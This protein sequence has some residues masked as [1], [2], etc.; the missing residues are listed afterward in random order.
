MYWTC[1][2]SVRSAGCSTYNDWL[3]S[4]L[5]E[6][7]RRHNR[8]EGGK[9]APDRSKSKGNGVGHS[10]IGIHDDLVVLNRDDAR[11]PDSVSRAEEMA[12]RLTS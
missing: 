12:G 1:Q 8:R 4:Q 2:R 11:H 9:G 7:E 10:K 5:V 3:A 6:V